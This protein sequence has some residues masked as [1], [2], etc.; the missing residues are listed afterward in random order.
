MKPLFKKV[1][2]FLEKEWFLLVVVSVITLIV[3]LFEKL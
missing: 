3:I 2:H 1:V